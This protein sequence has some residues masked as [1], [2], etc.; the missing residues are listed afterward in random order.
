MTSEKFA[1]PTLAH[2]LI[3]RAQA[4][5]DKLAF[6]Y[7]P[8]GESVSEQWTYGELEERAET[9]AEW[10]RREGARGERVLLLHEN[11]LHFI[12]GLFG[13]LLAGAVAVPAYSPVGKKQ[14]TRIGKIVND[15][16]ASFALTSTESL[17]ETRAAIESF[18]LAQSLRWCGSD[19]LHVHPHRDRPDRTPVLPAPDDL[20]LIQYTSGSTSDPKGV[21][22]THRNFMDNV[23]SIRGALGS[24]DLDDDLF[25]VFWLPLHHDMGLV[26]AV[27]TTVY[28]AGSSELMSPVSFVLRPI[29]WLER[30]SGRQRVITTAPNFAHELCVNTTTPEERARLDLSGWR[31]ALC[32]AEFVRVETMERFAEAFAPVGF[33]PAAAQP[34]YG[35]AEN[36]LLVTGSPRPDG[37]LVKYLSR[38]SLHERRVVD[39]D[40]GRDGSTAM[41]GC[42]RVQNGL[43]LVIVDPDTRQ[44]CPPEQVGE[45]WISSMSVAQGYWRQLEP[46]ATTF[47]AELVDPGDH[48]AGPYLR[49]GDLGFVSDHEL[50]VAG[51]LKDL[52]IVRGR[53][54]YPDD[55]EGSVQD[56]DAVLLRGR[57]A[58]FALDAG[59]GE[60][61][62]VVQEIE[63]DV[64]PDTDFDGICA[65]VAAVVAQE[66]EVAVSSVV[67]VRPYSLPSTS[68]GKVQRFACREKFAS[69]ALK[70]VAH[71]SPL[72]ARKPPSSSEESSGGPAANRSVREV[73]EW[74]VDHLARDLG[75][76]QEEIDPRRPFSYYGL[77]S[78][79]AV[80]LASAIGL[81]F[82]VE[83]RPTVA[84]E[85]PTIAELAEYLANP[86]TS[87]A[88]SA[89]AS[90]SQ[91]ASSNPVDTASG[92]PLAIVGIGCRFPGAD[93]TTAFWDLLREGVD[94][95][96][97][98][99]DDRWTRDDVRWGGFLDDVRSF[100]AEFFGISPREAEHIDPQQRL[101][102]ELTGEA[103]EDAGLVAAELAGEPV[104][105]F[106]GIST[107]DYGRLFY[108]AEDR[109][110]AYTGTGNAMS[111]AANRISYCFDFRGPSI[112]VDTA[113][114]SSLVALH[115]ACASLRSGESTLAVV[116]GVNLI[117]SPAISINMTKAGVMAADGRCKTFDA[118]ADGYVRSE[119]AGVVLLEP[120][121]RA[122]AAGHSIYAVIRGSATNHDGRTNG[123]MAPSKRSQAAL[124]R[125]AY[126]CAGVVPGDAVYVEAHGTGTL[127]GDAIEAN[128]L[129]EV[130]AEGRR[131]GETC[132]IGS[133]KSNIGHLEAAAGIAGVIKVALALRHRMIPP[134]LHYREVNPGIDLAKAPIRIADSL[135]A[136]PAGFG[137]A[138]V[139]SFGFG[140]T[141]AHV[142]LAAAPEAASGT[143]PDVQRPALLAI[144]AHGSNAL[145]ELAGRYRSLLQAEH[146]NWTD[147]AYS[148]AAH[149]SHHDN[150][151]ALV[152]HTSAE[153]ADQLAAFLRGDGRPGMSAGCARPGRPARVAFVF[154]GQ[155][156]Q[157]L[158]MGRALFVDEPAFREALI[159]CDRE[160]RRIT[161][162]S[163]IDE[164]HATAERSRLAEVDVVQP[165]LFA[166]QV[167]LAALWDSWGVTPDAVVGHSMGEV[168]AAHVAGVL[169]LADAALVIAHR[170]RLLRQVSGRG[171][172]AVV[173]LGPEQVERRIADYSDLVAIAA[174]NSPRST[175]LSGDPAALDEVLTTLQR[176]EIFCR[177]IKVDVASHGPQMDPLRP[178][179]VTA[180]ADIT[181]REGVVGVYSTVTGALEGSDRFT[182]EYW[183]DNLRKTVRF[184]PTVDRMIGDGYETFVE[185]APHP[186][187]T[188]AIT[189]I[190][191]TESATVVPSGARDGDEYGTLLASLGALYCVGYP[192]KWRA[193]H[194]DGAVF[195]RTP[196]YPWQRQTYWI[197]GPGPSAEQSSE[198]GSS[199]T[200]ARIDSSIHPG[201]AF[202]QWDISLDSMEFLRD[203]RVQ[204]TPTAPAA[205][206]MAVLNAAAGEK[207][208]G[209]AYELLDVTFDSPLLLADDAECRIQLAL[210][211]S[212]PGSAT[213]RSLTT[214]V[215]TATTSWEQL[216]R[217]TVRSIS[218]DAV[219]PSPWHPATDLDGWN[220]DIAGADFYHA[221][222]DVGLQYGPAFQRITQVW[223]RDAEALAHL[224]EESVA[225]RGFRTVLATTVQ[226]D[227]AFQVLAATVTETDAREDSLFL[228]VGLGCLRVFGD[229]A[230]A[231]WCHMVSSR[232]PVS[233]ADTLEGDF[234]L[235]AE[236]GR[237]L[238]DCTGLR[239]RRLSVDVAESDSAIPDRWFYQLSWQES[240]P[241]K[242]RATES[243]D[244]RWIVVGV[245][246]MADLVAE[247]LT[248]RGLSVLR[249]GTGR[250]AADFEGETIEAIVYL[251]GQAESEDSLVST[252]GSAALE[253]L[254]M[255]QAVA[256][257]EWAGRPPRMFVVTN[258]TQSAGT[259][260]VP[261]AAGIAAAP[262]WG[263]SR[264]LEHELPEFRC[265]RID[266]S[267]HPDARELDTLSRELWSDD[268]E[269]EIALRGDT[270]FVARLVRTSVPAA[271]RRPAYPA[272]GFAVT[273]R[274]PGLLEDLELRQTGRREPD[275]GEVEIRVLAAGLNF[276][277]VAVAAGVIPPEDDERVLLGAEC[278][279]RVISVGPEVE[280]IEPGDV[281]AAI[282]SPAFGSYVTTSSTLVVPITESL[283]PVAATTVP[284]A[285][286]TAYYALHELARLRRGER[287]LI[288]SATG[289]VGLAAIAL[290]RRA[291]A[292]IYATAGSP[293]KRDYLRALGVEHV[294][295]SRSLSFA[296]EIMRDTDGEGVD[297]ILNSLSGEAIPR[298]LG[299]LRTFGRF[300]EI[301]KRDIVEKRT[302]DLWQLRRNVSHFTVD[303][304]A[305]VLERPNEVGATLRTVMGLI[306]DGELTPLPATVFR[307]SQAEEAFR[308]MAKA[309]HIGKVVL[310]TEEI[311]DINVTMPR[312]RSDGQYL[313][314]GG[315]G[316]LGIEV[317]DWLVH[318]GA[319]NLVLTGRRGPDERAGSVIERLRAAGVGV[320][321]T[322]TDIS[323]EAD[324]AALMTTI[325][326][327]GL[328][329]RGI[330]HAAGTLA[331]AVFDRQDEQSLSEVFA[332]K[333]A[334]AWH[335][336]TATRDI[337]LDF[338]IYFS[339]AAGV[340]GSPG[341]SNYAGANAFLDALAQHR[342]SIGLAGTSIAWGPWSEVG[343]A[344]QDHRSAHVSNLGI[345]AISPAAGLSILDR[346]LVSNLIHSIVLPLD[347]SAWQ[348]VLAGIAQ[349]PR[350]AE[351][352]PAHDAAEESPPSAL[353]E[354]LRAATAAER[355]TILHAY[356]AAV[357]ATRL[358][359]DI[360]ALDHDRPLR[361]M[362]LD[363]IGA[364]EL[365]TRIE[366]DLPVT[367]PVIKLL[368]GPSVTEFAAWL[369]SQLDLEHTS[370]AAPV[371]A[372]PQNPR[373]SRNV[374]DQQAAELLADLAELSDKAVD[375][376]L[377]ELLAS[378][379]EAG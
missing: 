327:Q 140:G 254:H 1:E 159:R 45:I 120:L 261:D 23:E 351:L 251:G 123:M 26:G 96:S 195:V 13:C 283:D 281:V 191:E 372:H 125:R 222:A 154:S 36:T 256:R 99:P 167:A 104:G 79:R 359:I 177:L 38:S 42:G 156:S 300:V 343:L 374:D 148:A 308:Y 253:F 178:E 324:V 302:I 170:S 56:A 224:S 240:A 341:Q 313:V 22:L 76:A 81:S 201:T 4:Y 250:T 77:D 127:L 171:A 180:L 212:A 87:R 368:E 85:Y 64:L 8:D 37:P 86:H 209:C 181:P 124:L 17:P 317:A 267:R 215:D 98:V 338:M 168:A 218:R 16:G 51:R 14:V 53:N 33:D 135:E 204:S 379:G 63:R 202:W 66:Y 29:R 194:R 15:S 48:P 44:P 307:I 315:L 166:V 92:E 95:I 189:Q 35:L 67:L 3:A 54:L 274:A 153:A 176:D 358:G 259:P 365:R 40:P 352:L 272:E 276:H 184:G 97:E 150:R 252:A 273:Q 323:Q 337:A 193:L 12:A 69:G 6:A 216:S 161:G 89:S 228:P 70:T 309:R 237:V 172:M 109:I 121:S 126:A 233:D 354:E 49:T 62:I 348:S 303:I 131:P 265:T 335:L 145:R 244:R 173:E 287:V 319:R 27:L 41:V 18:E 334:G 30:I 332:P 175:I 200:T 185:I 28:V 113:C 73:S 39:V 295:N 236:D 206:H 192:V 7:L 270:R 94:A 82:G 320:T 116:G 118:A 141:N 366:R 117:L 238:A 370:A 207:F 357:V 288:H 297:V 278:V 325:E 68:S 105:V 59:A 130:L 328:P 377:A 186:V 241:P 321:V 227:A 242:A 322:S 225:P 376:L 364:M 260:D 55:L 138:G 11:D 255:M 220:D 74:L 24:P 114:S 360:D 151:L 268:A 316:G 182:A 155:G 258:G 356:L 112:A 304:A 349:L 232:R 106:L 262:L 78:V 110:D 296:E 234:Q 373:S 243:A 137:V 247:L 65:R 371:A 298:G 246:P 129:A 143:T 162:W 160:I 277:D 47:Y 292:E 197:G 152:A 355:G 305:M 20:A 291:G 103:L 231:R 179:L 188:A 198:R 52:I 34:V 345:G 25:G 190:R 157:W 290:A 344:S 342:R 330:V 111:V 57:G 229:I 19:A 282:A 329:L 183:G 203:H 245:D 248:A 115:E 362:G 353:I 311:P 93:G 169:D 275:A 235:L 147:I 249:S 263:M 284:I 361:Y 306:A 239:V 211:D 293:E 289:G 187:L 318:R 84:Y 196:A 264:T 83:L 221:L 139:S 367:V 21:M 32:G 279:G 378:E 133:V 100:D 58:A 314:T 119:G 31:T 369:V 146:A 71:W 10:L 88:A 286:T 214:S 223:R 280:G 208:D 230:T 43:Q 269:T 226:L 102:L 301:G 271:I 2:L 333:V 101:V 60:Q 336:H 80:K 142:V 174:R 346:I 310:T 219:A 312:L 339:S 285:F 163:V 61:L 294:M 50:F 136:W 158:G 257:H 347:R 5:R 72:P 217:G 9:V 205:L 165:T 164:L 363:S 91:Q 331:D 340:L 134:T 46:T 90:A 199:R 132:A 75:V 107:N 266:I 108:T 128:A 213:F 149:R 299:V 375:E 350:F 210:V 144:S 122:E 326:S